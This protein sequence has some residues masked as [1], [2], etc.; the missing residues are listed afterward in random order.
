M[1]HSI[2]WVM[3]LIQEK[4]KK[5]ENKQVAKALKKESRDIRSL[6]SMP[7]ESMTLPSF[8]LGEKKII[9]FGGKGGV[10][11]TTCSTSTSLLLSELYPN[12]KIL[13]LSLD[14]AHSLSD[15][16]DQ[17]ITDKPTKITQNLWAEEVNA[18]ALY[19]EW[20]DQNKKYFLTLANRGTYFEEKDLEKFFELS[21]P[22]IDEV[23]G[24]FYLIKLIEEK[25]YD[26]L[27]VDTA[28]TGHTLRLL[29]LPYVMERW[30]Y[31]F[32]LM[33]E[34]HRYLKAHFSRNLNPDE[35][36]QF[37]EETQSKLETFEKIL[38]DRS[39]TEFVVVT[40]AEPMALFEA[41]RLIHKLD[42]D[43]IATQNV[44]VNRNTP[45]NS[46]SFCHQR[47]KT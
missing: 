11:K 8:L 25:T 42:Q 5:R 43:G 44:V 17:K 33:Q 45:Q 39:Q 16:L 21:I 9:F 40:I 4:F 30:I 41:D 23:M 47:M 29:N 22:G 15:S 12:K 34:K 27:V 46:C 6:G 14:P 19:Q 13:L 1:R 3:G 10:G 35:S 26:I 7:I 28:P 20:M 24:I 18:K 38:Q 2:P 36:D 37:L 32:N 31:V